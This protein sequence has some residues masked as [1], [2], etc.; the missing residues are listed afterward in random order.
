MNETIEGIA[1]RSIA[2]VEQLVANLT[3]ME[4]ME[5]DRMAH[6]N[7]PSDTYTN[8]LE[9]IDELKLDC[10]NMTDGF[11]DIERYQRESKRS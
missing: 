11:K 9:L 8:T 6:T 1:K 7:T 5:Y 4:L 3:R 2:L 10:S